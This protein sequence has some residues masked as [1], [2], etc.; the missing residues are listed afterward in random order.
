MFDF[1]RKTFIFFKISIANAL[2]C[3]YNGY[4]HN[5]SMVPEEMNKMLI[6]QKVNKDSP[7]PIYH[8]VFLIIKE[9]I[10][11]NE[12]KEG[13]FLPSERDLCEILDVS[14]ITIRK[15]LYELENS[16][17]IKIEHGKPTQ[18]VKRFNPLVWTELNNFSRD[19][20]I[21]GVNLTSI[22]LASGYVTP[23]DKV[24]R[25]LNLED[26]EKVYLLKR[27]RLAGDHKIALNISYLVDPHMNIYSREYFDENVSIKKIWAKNGIELSCCDE[28]IE[29][30]IPSKE[31][32]NVLDLDGQTA[33]FQRER[34]TY[35]K[36]LEPIEYVIQIFNANYA[37]YYIEK[38]PVT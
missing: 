36:D 21:K 3:C 37:K 38:G 19:M 15:A 23:S 29:A 14:R 5:T 35:G 2:L 22:I 16:G 33:V 4:I 7:V 31:I 24:K 8:Q 34:V 25:M 18:V 13:D 20:I 28:T 11:S 12:V 1:S 32:V 27:I 6:N 17:Y 10:D 9:L 30:K 26:D